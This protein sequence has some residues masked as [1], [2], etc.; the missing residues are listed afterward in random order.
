MQV[1]LPVSPRVGAGRPEVDHGGNIQ[2]VEPLCH[3]RGAQIRCQLDRTSDDDLIEHCSAAVLNTWI[4]W[5]VVGEAWQP[6]PGAHVNLSPPK[7]LCV[8]QWVMFSPAV[9]VERTPHVLDV[10]NPADP[11]SGSPDELLS[12]GIAGLRTAAVRRNRLV[13]TWVL[14]GQIEN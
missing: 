12:E 4:R 14:D 13:E 3:V 11:L 8:D 10:I 6:A 2:L 5:C 7:L 9:A 1:V